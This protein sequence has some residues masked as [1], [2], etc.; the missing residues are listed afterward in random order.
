MTVRHFDGIQRLRQRTDLVDFDEDGVGAAQLDAFF[1][2]VHVRHEEVVADQLAA[3]TEAL[4]QEFPAIPVALRHPVLD[5]VDGIFINELRE[6]VSL[7]CRCELFAPGALFPRIVVEAGGLVIELAGRAVHGKPHIPARLVAGRLDGFQDGLDGILRPIQGRSE[8]ALVPHGRGEAARFQD[9]LQRMEHLDAHA[10]A[11][12]EGRRADRTD[13]EL[14]EADGCVR[15]RP[16]IDDIHH[17]NGERIRV[18]PA[19]VTVQGEVQRICGCLG[20][21]QGHAEDGIRAE[22]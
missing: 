5:G 16:R 12:M 20:N 7:F 2:V 9:L 8:T 13:H 1:Q 6:V 10:D 15:M 11:L 18:R 19:E 4:R 17:R 14:L 21:G 22:V 3:G